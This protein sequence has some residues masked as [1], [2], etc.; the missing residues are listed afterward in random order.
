[1]TSNLDYSTNVGSANNSLNKTPL[2]AYNYNNNGYTTSSTT[3]D[4]YSASQN[5]QYGSYFK[6][7]NDN[8]EVTPLKPTAAES[9]LQSY[10]TTQPKSE[11]TSY[12]NGWKQYNSFYQAQHSEYGSTYVNTLNCLLD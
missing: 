8:R 4:N 10:T 11:P 3:A 2:S 12:I 7:M 9:E 5:L 6:G 1:M